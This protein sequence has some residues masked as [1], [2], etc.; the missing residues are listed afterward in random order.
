MFEAPEAPQKMEGMKKIKSMSF[1][2]FSW[3]SE[4]ETTWISLIGWHHKTS[5]TYLN[6]IYNLIQ[7]TSVTL[8]LPKYLLP[9]DTIASMNLL[10][11]TVLFVHWQIAQC[12]NF[13][14][15][16]FTRTCQPSLPTK[17][18]HPSWDFYYSAFHW[19]H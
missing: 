8:A 13:N 11:A 12:Y 17:T 5:N 6:S 16:Q 10:P 2:H 3:N 19:T 4:V 9:N 7:M 1:H 15:R 14:L 18:G